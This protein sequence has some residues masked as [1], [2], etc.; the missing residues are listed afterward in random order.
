MMR[1]TPIRAVLLAA[2]GAAVVLAGDAGTAVSA[3]R[4]RAR[5]ASPDAAQTKRF[6]TGEVRDRGG[7]ARSRGE[8]P[9][10]RRGGAA[11]R[12]GRERSEDLRPRAIFG[13]DDR[14]PVLD[15]TA[16]PYAAVCKVFAEFPYGDVLE[17]SAILVSERHALT[18]GHVIHDAALGGFAERV[19]VIP[20]YDFGDAPFGS[21]EAA[22]VTA[23]TGWTRDRD[24]DWDVA[25]LALDGDP[26]YDTGWLGFGAYADTTLAGATVHTAGYPADRDAGRAMWGASGIAESVLPGQVQF[27]GALDAARG[28]SGSGLWLRFSDGRYVA[29]I[30]S[31]ETSTWN[32]ATRITEPMFDALAAWMDEELLPD[33]RPVSV[34]ALPA[35]V[36][37]PH[38]ATIPVAVVNE[39]A[40]PASTDV[41]LFARDGLY[42][43]T[44]IGRA[45]V[46]VPAGS[47]V[48][49]YVQANVRPA[50][51]GASYDLVA[52]VNPEDEVAE[53]ETAD[54]AIAGRE[55][56][57]MP[58]FALLA[59]FATAYRSMEPGAID[60][61]VL[62]VPAGAS[63][64]RL[65]L[66]GAFDAAAE[67]RRPDG[68]TELLVSGRRN[69]V[70]E[71]APAP[72][73]WEIDLRRPLDGT[74][75]RTARLR[76]VVR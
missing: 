54:D 29:G 31:S 13:A 30:V 14:F 42:A 37:A 11:A 69:A 2:T 28:Q 6:A 39:G 10:R 60:R 22:D 32:R 48:T 67:V 71:F 64:L 1:R 24:F 20:A 34:G 26:G 19:T 63:L 59:P 47:T 3:P 62:D 45:R 66:T 25:L 21:F 46:H 5:S 38:A 15:P 12:S 23:F 9:D 17:G 53:S 75:I 35:E 65:V 16:Y 40:A 61:F 72:G 56:A 55:F 8:Q 70:A 68:S 41:A 57:V 51:A 52:E 50:L 36:F 74:R 7:A 33:F 49:A 76:A 73:R 58:D 18:A 4:D 27:R 43:R 44:E